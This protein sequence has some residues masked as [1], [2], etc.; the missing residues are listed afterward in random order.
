MAKAGYDLSKLVIGLKSFFQR[1]A[2]KP[3]KK[4]TAADRP[5]GG[6]FTED[7]IHGCYAFLGFNSHWMTPKR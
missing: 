4:I 2:K 6:T 3:K 1:T 5:Y 7:F